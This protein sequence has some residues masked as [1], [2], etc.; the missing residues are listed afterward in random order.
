MAGHTWLDRDTAPFADCTATAQVFRDQDRP[1]GNTA[2]LSW[3]LLGGPRTVEMAEYET[4]PVSTKK[5]SSDIYWYY[6]YS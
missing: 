3:P 2:V 6:A 5:N 1:E 4:C